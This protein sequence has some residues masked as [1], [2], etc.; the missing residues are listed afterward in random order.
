[1]LGAG[2]SGGAGTDF[3]ELAHCTVGGRRAFLADGPAWAKST[4]AEH[5]SVWGVARA[6]SQ[7]L[8]MVGNVEARPGMLTPTN[9][10]SRGMSLA[11]CARRTPAP[12]LPEPN[13]FSQP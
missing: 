7:G 10:N 2:R 5:P 1:M 12:V 6:G 13:P 4:R 8:G 9:P 3:P 11:P